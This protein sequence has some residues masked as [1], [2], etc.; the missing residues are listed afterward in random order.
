MVSAL[1]SLDGKDG[2]SFHTFTLPEDCCVRLLVKNLVRSMPES[3]VRKE[4]ESLNIRVQG[5]TQLQSGHHD[6]DSAK[7][8]PPTPHFIVS[9]ARGPEVSKVWSLTELCGLRVPMEPY[10]APKGPLQCKRFQRF[11]HTQRNC[12][13]T[14][15]WVSRRGSHLSS[16]CCNPREQ[17]QCCGCGGNYT[18][19]YHGCVKW[20]EA[21]AALAKQ[22]PKRSWKSVATGQPADPKAQRAGPSAEQMDLGDGWNHVTRR[23]RV[24]KATT[25]PPTNLH[26][27]PPPQPV[28]EALVKPIVTATRQTTRP[29]KIWAQIQSSP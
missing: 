10:V 17:P 25:I 13:H 11:G 4:L 7:D 26:S 21:S 20:K 28:M 5:V 16:G 19:N 23:G 27:N 14:P 29:K 2:V 15:R 22:A 1:W 3:V 9:V 8:R 18:A 12:G 6:L 24:V